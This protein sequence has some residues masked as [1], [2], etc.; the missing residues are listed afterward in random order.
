MPEYTPDE[1]NQRFEL[2]GQYDRRCVIRFLQEAETDHVSV[3]DVVDHLQKHGRTT[4]ERDKLKMTL[5]HHHL[6]KLAST[7]VADFD[8]RSETLRYQGDELVETLLEVAPE[9][10]L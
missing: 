3:D 7:A 8:S 4:D 1:I 5:N 2:L 10:G 6:P 9:T